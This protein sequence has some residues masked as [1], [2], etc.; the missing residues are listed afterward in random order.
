MGHN[1]LNNQR[2]FIFPTPGVDLFFSDSPQLPKQLRIPGTSGHAT[3]LA[4]QCC[5]GWT[6]ERF[7]DGFPYRNLLGTILDA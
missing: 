5:G 3:P 1:M 6:W 7:S 2:V 4:S